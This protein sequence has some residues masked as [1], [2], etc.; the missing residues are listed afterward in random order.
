MRNSVTWGTYSADTRTAKLDGDNRHWVCEWSGE[1]SLGCESVKASLAGQLAVSLAWEALHPRPAVSLPG[2]LPPNTNPSPLSPSPSYLAHGYLFHLS[3]VQHV[4]QNTP[5]WLPPT[6]NTSPLSP[7]PSF[8]AH[9]SLFHLSGVHHVQRNTP[10][11]VPVHWFAFFSFINHLSQS[12]SIRTLFYS[13]TAK[14]KYMNQ[15][16]NVWQ[17]QTPLFCKFNH[18]FLPGGVLWEIDTP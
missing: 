10:G 3:G 1:A 8:L 2:W 13:F 9:R 15:V 4:Q 7:S 5:G 6:T 16:E 17:S 14:T 18:V 11:W 12:K